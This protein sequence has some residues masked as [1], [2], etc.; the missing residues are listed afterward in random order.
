MK[1]VITI[2]LGSILLISSVGFTYNVFTCGMNHHVTISMRAVNLCCGAKEMPMGC[3]NNQLHI[4]K[5]TADYITASA[6][7]LP[8]KSPHSIVIPQFELVQ[9]LAP[10]LHYQALHSALLH[11]PP[12]LLS[13]VPSH[14]LF[15]SILV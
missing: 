15:R 11:A 3:C 8:A 4:V 7:D 9:I 14:I 1:R 12:I 6:H 2:L 13:S 5:F 10:E